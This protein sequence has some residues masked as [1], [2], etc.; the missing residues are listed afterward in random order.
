MGEPA[1]FCKNLQMAK[2]F[3]YRFLG[4]SHPFFLSLLIRLGYY[5]CTPA[6]DERQRTSSSIHRFTNRTEFRRR[7]SVDSKYAYNISLRSETS[8]PRTS[9]TT[10]LYSSN[11]RLHAQSRWS[12][13]SGVHAR[14][15]HK[16]V[17]LPIYSS[18]GSDQVF[19]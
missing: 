5:L 12:L 1:D 3:L 6:P 14:S 9:V 7:C 17:R 8:T 13:S 10:S 19:T 18:S 2:I 11:N 15:Y 16:M 4:V